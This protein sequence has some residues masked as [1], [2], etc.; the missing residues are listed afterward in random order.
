MPTVT[1]V[2]DA[3]ATPPLA[4]LQQV[5]DTAG[6]YGPGSHT[7]DTFTTN[8]AFLLPAG[9]YG[10]SGTYGVIAQV[11]G[12][13]PAA[14]GRQM[15][16]V[17]PAGVIFASGELYHDLIGQ[18]NLIHFLPIT[19]AGVITEFHDLHHI[20]E[21]FLW[22]SLIGSAAKLGLYVGPNWHLDLFYMCVL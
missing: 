19:G 4:T 21:L 1:D 12:L 20:S 2:I 15:G 8:G 18:V 17:D 14:A 5:R 13:F 3:I 11:S 6:P 9:T 10:I 22:P 7:L 16:Y